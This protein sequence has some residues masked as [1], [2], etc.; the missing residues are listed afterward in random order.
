MYIYIYIYR[1]AAAGVL[2]PPFLL[3]DAR[4]GEHTPRARGDLLIKLHGNQWQSSLAAVEASSPQARVVVCA[5]VVNPPPSQ[6]G[7][8]GR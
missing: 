2:T 1:E 6:L 8:H 4:V 3:Y 5:A 7:C